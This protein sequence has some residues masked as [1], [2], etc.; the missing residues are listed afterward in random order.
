MLFKN[1]NPK[2]THQLGKKSL[3]WQ[4][5]Q[6]GWVIPY[7]CHEPHG[8]S[9]SPRITCVSGRE[10]E[11]KK[12]H[13]H[14]SSRANSNGPRF[15]IVSN[16]CLSVWTTQ[17]LTFLIQ[18]VWGICTAPI[19]KAGLSGAGTSAGSKG[20]NLWIQMCFGVM[21]PA[22]LW[23]RAGAARSGAARRGAEREATVRWQAAV[24]PDYSRR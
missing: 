12:E 5:L 22:G 14:S 21:R 4:R 3:F 6:T 11:K 8:S 17:S 7:Y 1:K 23:R 10:K 19:A 18:I 13:I 15:K 16:V 2:P 20:S 9:R 24:Q